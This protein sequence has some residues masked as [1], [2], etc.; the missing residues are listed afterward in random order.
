[1]GPRLA[2]IVP[3][4]AVLLGST[5]AFA[6]LRCGNR[7]VSEGERA[8]MLLAVCGEP[9][10]RQ[11]LAGVYL[12]GLGLLTDE[13]RW[14]YNFGPHQLIRVV[15]IRQGRIA[16]IDTAGYGFRPSVRGDCPPQRLAVG[17]N[18]LELLARCGEPAYKDLRLQVRPPYPP[19]HGAYDVVPVEEWVYTFGPTGLTRILTI[20][21]GTV[22]RVET[23][24]RP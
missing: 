5:P 1:M 19:E 14:Y 10:Y 9:G 7:L 8:Y 4:L 6:A 22:R 24:G 16:A 20:V 2:W 13:E 11:R 21:E 12:P 23:G 15:R 3:L 18:L 17:M